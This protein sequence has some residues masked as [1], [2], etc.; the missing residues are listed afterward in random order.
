MHGAHGTKCYIVL[1]GLARIL[2]PEEDAK[3][4]VIHYRAYADIGP[5][6]VSAVF[7]HPFIVSVVCYSY[8][9]TVFFTLTRGAAVCSWLW[10]PAIRE[11]R[12]RVRH[13]L[14][15]IVGTLCATRY[16]ISGTMHVSYEL[17]CCLLGAV[18]W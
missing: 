9:R 6:D 1:R 15:F 14:L 4:G 3:T 12:Y 17:R 7:D 8:I 2:Q 16:H 5:G 11:A 18:A 10:F 13:L